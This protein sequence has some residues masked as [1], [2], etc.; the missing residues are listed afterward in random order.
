MG[1]DDETKEIMGLNDTDSD[2]SQTDSDSDDSDG[3]ENLAS[4]A[5]GNQE[6][7]GLEDEMDDK[8]E[9]D[10]SDNEDLPSIL[11][12]EALED[13]VYVLAIEPTV[14]HGCIACPGKILKGEQMI[15]IHKMSQAR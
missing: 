14:V 11:I 7:S 3:E 1:L 6:D 5:E 15:S 13:P 12:Q 10:V 4:E 2:E 9:Q 8:D